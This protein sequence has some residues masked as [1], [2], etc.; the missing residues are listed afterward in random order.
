[1]WDETSQSLDSLVN[2]L[3]KVVI[4]IKKVIYGAL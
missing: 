4:K 3:L 1:M 2:Q